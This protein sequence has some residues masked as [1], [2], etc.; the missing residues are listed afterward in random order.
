MSV[1]TSKPFSDFDA[2]QIQ[3]KAFN[4]SNATLG[5][6]GFIVGQVGRS[7]VRSDI[8]SI[9][10]DYSFYEDSGATLLY[11][12]RIVYTDNTQA[13]LASVTRTA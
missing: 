7:I 6:D 11:T 8:D 9:T 4:D 5:V 3:R 1:G 10:E 12:I 13:K 2:S